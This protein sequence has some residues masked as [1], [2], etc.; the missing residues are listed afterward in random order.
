MR[1]NIPIF[2]GVSG[3]VAVSLG[4]FGAHFLAERLSDVQLSAFKTGV[5]YQFIHTLA[6]M[7]VYLFYKRSGKP[8]FR[9]TCY[10]FL[11]GILFFSGS[12]YLLSCKDIIG[13][14][15]L[16]IMGPITP[17]GG[18][19]FIA[20]WGLFCFGSLKVFKNG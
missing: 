8:A 20:G 9:H 14:E 12:L 13:M 3:L 6:C 1:D 18:L 10:I 16:K 7:I 5:N 4:A 17:F 19:F 11:I 2:C 15:F